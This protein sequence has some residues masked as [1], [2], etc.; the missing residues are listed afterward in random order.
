MDKLPVYC[1][2]APRPKPQSR[3][4]KSLLA[5]VLLAVAS[6]V[7]VGTT[8]D[9]QDKISSKV[10]INAAEI[11]QHC[12][13]L[14]VQPGPPQDFHHRSHSDRFVPGTPP[15]LIK[16]A[17][18]WTGRESG[19]EVVNGDLLLDRGLVKAIGSVD[20]TSLLDYHNL[21]TIEAGGAWVT[22]GYSILL[23]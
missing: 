19:N 23:P 11:V 10:P 3:I 8:V 16:N 21:V 6:L 7:W 22:P 20:D 13:L 4:F 9:S 12:Q 5:A 1:T 17:T 18:I 15:T 2:D 14:D